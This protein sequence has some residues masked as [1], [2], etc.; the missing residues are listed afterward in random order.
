MV[1][2][3]SWLCCNF[4]EPLISSAEQSLL[5]IPS[6]YCGSFAKTFWAIHPF[7]TICSGA[8]GSKISGNWTT[9]NMLIHSWRHSCTSCC[10]LCIYI[11]SVLGTSQLP[12]LLGHGLFITKGVLYMCRWNFCLGSLMWDNGTVMRLYLVWFLVY[13]TMISTVFV[14]DSGRVTGSEE[15]RRTWK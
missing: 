4:T 7:K 12:F 14:N 13:F 15:W 2:Y 6:L 11:I 1:V 9:L 5:C 10:V 3:R 8:R